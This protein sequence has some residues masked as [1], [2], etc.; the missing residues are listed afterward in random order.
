M[1]DELLKFDPA[2][3]EPNPYPSHAGQWRAHHGK[4]AWLFNPWT[5]ARRSAE[6]IGTDTQGR[7]I[8]LPGYA[9]AAQQDDAQQLRQA[10][11]EVCDE[12]ERKL[13]QPRSASEDGF[14][15]WVLVSLLNRRTPPISAGPGDQGP[16][17][18][19]GCATCATP[20]E[21]ERRGCAGLAARVERAERLA[22][23]AI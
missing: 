17:A 14:L 10:V 12:I 3:G 8:V 4:T 1:N 11:G 13:R 6:D 21:C 22:R 20:D 2:T 16:A 7:L 9:M 15:S 19:G 23:G 18:G 5:G